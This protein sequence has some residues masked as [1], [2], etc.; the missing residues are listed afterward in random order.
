MEEENEGLFYRWVKEVWNEGKE[1]TIDE[2]FAEDGVA[3]YPNYLEN[4]TIYGKEEYKNF[5]RF[6][7]G[8]FTDIRVAVEQIA[9]DKNKVI[10]Y[11]TFNANRRGIVT[12][13]VSVDSAISV[14]GLCQMIFENGVIIRAWCNIDLFAVPEPIKNRISERV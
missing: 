2:L 6:I 8:L 13:G 14:S 9:S 4:P 12:K 11:C 10:A 7:H 5:A 1:A 3:D